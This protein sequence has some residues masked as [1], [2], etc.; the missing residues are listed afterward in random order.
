MN[1]EFVP[2]AAFIQFF[3][4]EKLFFKHDD[5]IVTSQLVVHVCEV[6]IMWFWK[7]IPLGK[8]ISSQ[9]FWEKKAERFELGACLIV[10][11]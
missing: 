7:S 3:Q 8:M 4:V 5:V 6:V 9:T 11:I 10:P 1:L 2:I